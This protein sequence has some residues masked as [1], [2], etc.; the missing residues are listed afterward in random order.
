MADSTSDLFD[1]IRQQFDNAP[2][3][4]T[5]LEIS[6]QE[7]PSLLYIHNLVTPYYLRNQKVLDT[8]D[9]IILDAGCGSGYKS[10]V[11]AAANPGAK[12]I[13][14]DISEESIKLAKQRLEYHGIENAEFYVLTLQEINQLNYKY[15][16]INCDEILYLFPDISAALKTLK[17][18]LEPD[19]IIRSNLHSSIQRF[20]FFC[21][22]KVFKLMGLLDG[23]PGE[24]EAEIVSETMQALKDD[25]RLKQT[26]WNQMYVDKKDSQGIFMNFLFQ[27]D[28]GYTIADMF[29]ALKNADLEFI[30]M[31]NWRQ[32]NLLNLFKE[33]DNLPIFW[34]MSL[35][36]ISVE[37]QLQLFELINPIHRLLDFWCGHPEQ[38]KIYI[39]V[40]EWTVQQW[41]TATVH[42]HPQLKTP[43]FQEDL[44]ACLQEGKIFTLHKHLTLI[45]LPIELDSSMLVCLLRLLEQ[46]QPMMFLVEQWK[47]FR[48][49]NPVTLVPTDEEQA[50][51]LVRQFLLRLESFGYLL[52]ESP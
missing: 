44:I 38:G 2:Y 3:P 49:F 5:P 22:Q 48:P 14:I 9:K 32:W 30:S 43:Q 33:P 27:G 34:G 7:F 36:D 47:Q 46:P 37:Q 8:K 52:L 23:N 12:I 11:L 19:G 29:T 26:T 28:K 20:N 10:L 40:T 16:Y 15:H 25:V 13:G 4:D 17:S 50:F 21:A 45:D 1:K 31:V 6:P 24:L 41:K 51:N 42:L 39:P 35:E 18:V